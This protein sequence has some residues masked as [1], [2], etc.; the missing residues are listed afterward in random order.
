MWPFN[1]S[2]HSN[3]KSVIIVDVGTD[4][5]G[6]AIVLL[7]DGQLPNIQ[8]SKRTPII[9]SNEPRTAE[10]L[11]VRVR[12][13]ARSAFDL[14]TSFFHLNNASGKLLSNL[15]IFLNAPWSSL[16]M[17]NVKFAPQE[18]THVNKAMVDK[19]SSGYFGRQKAGEE[20]ALIDRALFNVRFDG[21]RIETANIPRRAPLLWNR[22]QK[23]P[24]RVEASALTIGAYR[25][26]TKMLRDEVRRSFGAAHEPSFYSAATSQAQA[27][28]A[29]QPSR[30]DFV[31]CNTGG[32][33]TGVLV[34]REH[35]PTAFAT[36]PRG[37]DFSVRTLATHHNFNH[38]EALSA[39]SIAPREAPISD[40]L[41][42]VL[43]DA[44]SLY[45]KDF[46]EAFAGVAPFTGSTPVFYTLG[47]SADERWASRLIT[48]SPILKN[49]YPLGVHSSHID[50]ALLSKAGV[51]NVNVGYVP[52]ARL[53][54]EAV[55]CKNVL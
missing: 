20:E 55:F 19:M 50:N 38:Y 28:G 11:A 53:Q 23:A 1:S 5:V 12:V 42:G 30:G 8:Y 15:P 39:V 43:C 36:M 13:A 49:I 6:C 10:R 29:L 52:D 46:E 18:N 3:G 37:S 7:C 2:H 14:A 48:Q 22:N 24:S 9:F 33:V 54:L 44:E 31:L 40:R 16:Y 51:V 27:L 4:S 35:A 41:G 32:E 17:R 26:L 34:V 47:D 21:R 45:T 25:P